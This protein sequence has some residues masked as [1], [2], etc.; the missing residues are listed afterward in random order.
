[1]S[2]HSSRVEA[3]RL[4]QDLGGNRELADVVEERRVAERPESPAARPSSPPIASAKRCTR[5]ECRC[6]VASPGVGRG[7]PGQRERRRPDDRCRVE[8]QGDRPGTVMRGRDSPRR[9]RCLPAARMTGCGSPPRSRSPAR[10]AGCPA[11]PGAVAARRSRESCSLA[12]DPGAVRRLAARAP[13]R[14]RARLGDERQDDDDG[15]GRR[16]PR[17]APPARAQPGGREPALGRR[18]DAARGAGRRGARAARGRRGGAARRSRG[19][20][21]RVPSA[22]A[23]SSATSSTATASSSSWPSAGA[24]L[25]RRSTGRQSSS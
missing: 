4:E 12:L 13:A 2:A 10:S 17:A 23:T 22:S 8:T 25:S 7:Q 20:S 11:S 21:T 1:M 14:R 16:D 15:D 19:R 9:R 18:L 5:R 3:R 24:T 6:R